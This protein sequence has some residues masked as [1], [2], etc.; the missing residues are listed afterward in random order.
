V[1]SDR[2]FKLDTSDLIAA[3]GMFGEK[4]RDLSEPM[5]VIAES[6]VTAV[7]DKF[8]QSGPGWPPLSEYTLSQRRGSVAQILYD[9]GIL[10]G[11]IEAEHGNNWA[12]ASTSVEYAIYHVS[13]QPRSKI[14]LRDFFDVDPGVFDDAADVIIE[15][16]ARA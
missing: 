9:T 7:N 8:D 4:A 6:L 14:P 2:V 1:G 11:S 5:S 13:D 16:L 15:F 10:S 3:I 12:E